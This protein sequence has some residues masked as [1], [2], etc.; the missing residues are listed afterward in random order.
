MQAWAMTSVGLGLHLKLTPKLGAPT[1]GRTWPHKVHI[2]Y[3]M[4][5]CSSACT[6]QSDCTGQAPLQQAGPAHTCTSMFTYEYTT[7][8]GPAD[9]LSSVQRCTSKLSVV[10]NTDCI[11]QR[12]TVLSGV[13]F[14]SSPQSPPHSSISKAQSYQDNPIPTHLL[15]SHPGSQ[16]TSPS[17]TEAARQV[18]ARR[19]EAMRGTKQGRSL[20]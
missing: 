6:H 1:K 10:E 20:T 13:K 11:S 2:Q 14:P 16:A 8:T 17:C 7:H 4:E 9:T 15:G 12:N 18:G 5:C 19:G 3:K